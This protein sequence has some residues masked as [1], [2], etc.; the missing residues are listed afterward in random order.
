MACW[1]SARRFQMMYI[2]QATDPYYKE[3]ASKPSVYRFRLPGPLTNNRDILSST[4]RTQMASATD[5]YDEYMKSNI[6]CRNCACGPVNFS[7]YVGCDKTT[8][9]YS[10]TTKY[11]EF[12]SLSC[13]M[14]YTE[15]TYADESH[16]P[17]PLLHQ[18]SYQLPAYEPCTD[19]R[20][21]KQP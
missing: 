14:S 15:K 4:P 18:L 8:N 1:K 19:T 21:R 11:K 3:I 17:T 6:R 9:V 13:C 12:C 2:F 16:N 5:A 7:T 10:V 20:Q